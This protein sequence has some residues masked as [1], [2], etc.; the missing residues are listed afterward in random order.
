[1]ELYKLTDEISK[2]IVAGI[3]KGYK[4]YLKERIQ[5]NEELII[6]NAYAWVKGNHIDH[7][8]AEE[9][10]AFGITYMKAKAGY[11]WGYLQFKNTDEKFLFL[12]KS[13]TSI[14]KD[15]G[16]Q[17]KK[18]PDNYIEKLAKINSNILFPTETTSKNEQM[19]LRLF[20][21]VPMNDIISEDDIENL[22]KEEFERFYIVTYTLDE[23]KMISD[24]SLTLPHPED[25]N[26]LY[27]VDSWNRYFDKVDIDFSTE[28]FNGIRD[29][30]EIETQISIGDYGIVID[31]ADKASDTES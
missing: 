2:S 15:K 7:Y 28:D 17:S 1:M 24:I 20:D 13:S 31:E 11:S 26:N 6:S 9:S 5:K 14:E 10:K 30:K 3:M 23:N 4:S 21:N 25:I 18:H 27:K 22:N 29:D 16:K 19:E 12:I 8:V